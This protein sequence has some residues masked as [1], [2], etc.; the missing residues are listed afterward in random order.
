MPF[1]GV[2]YAR[3]S[4]QGIRCGNNDHDEPKHRPGPVFPSG[5]GCYQALT[6]PPPDPTAGSITVKQTLALLDGQFESVAAGVA[7][8]RYAFWL[9][10]GISRGRLP[11]LSGV[12]EMVLDFLHSRIDPARRGCAHRKALEEAVDLAGL[13]D[14]E[15]AGID[16][17]EPVATWSVR[18]L[19]VDGLVSRYAEL[20]DIRVQG[21]PADYLLWEAVDVR[22]TYP[23]GAPPDCE[24]LC[25]AILAAEGVVSQAVSANWDGLIE[26][27][28]EEIAGDPDQLLRVVVLAA[29]LREPERRACLLKLHGCALLAARD[30]TTY[31][32]A[33]VAAQSQIT[34]WPNAAETEVMRSELTGIATT[35]PTLMIGLSAQDSNI[36]DLFARAKERMSWGW[37]EDPPAHVFA[38]DTLG[39]KHRSLLKVVYRDH[40]E[41][42]GAEIE[43]A[44]VSAPTHS[45]CHGTRALRPRR[46]ATCIVE[47]A[48][49]PHLHDADR[50]GLGDGLRELR[51]QL[52]ANAEPDRLAFVRA[53]VRTETRG[54]SLFEEGVEPPVGTPTYRPLTSEPTDQ[55]AVNPALATSGL[56]ELAA[57]LGLLGCGSADGAWQASIGPTP[58]GHDGALKV[59]AS[60][61]TQAAVYFAA[62]GKA[63]VQL[64]VNGTVEASH[65]DVVMIHSTG[66][67]VALPRS[68]RRRFG[69]TGHGGVRNVDM[70]D[71]LKTSGDLDELKR[72]FRQAA[73]L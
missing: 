33:L 59:I 53:M 22:T 42:H 44:P 57:A 18:E 52:A 73:A 43:Q 50:D 3:A 67:V 40:Y 34:S 24:H 16:F 8:G 61:G 5:P 64:E 47:A 11:D 30:P 4:P 23:A 19:L 35:K 13:R 68:S 21:Q 37:P 26:S 9:G 12:V 51:D 41:E 10:S 55:V 69:R 71:L 2:A 49:A 60:S 36:Q 63:A 65:D 46:K 54:L 27:A 38:G 56:R 28:V 48:D 31:R 1:R 72:R 20:L 62:N 29:D 7:N 25:L 17:A 70:Y 15:R 14:D 45:N 58:L 32:G 66:P 39:T 6:P